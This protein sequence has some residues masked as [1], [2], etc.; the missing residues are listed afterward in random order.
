[1]HSEVLSLKKSFGESF[2]DRASQNKSKRD[3]GG[4]G[5]PSLYSTSSYAYLTHLHDQRALWRGQGAAMGA[6]LYDIDAGAHACQPGVAE[7]DLVVIV[8]AV[9]G[10]KH[11]ESFAKTRQCRTRLR[12]TK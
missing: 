1:M 11:R 12:R 3:V 10:G 7:I 6:G 8:L 2:E 9:S 5:Y 4:G